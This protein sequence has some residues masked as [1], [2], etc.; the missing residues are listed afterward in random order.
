MPKISDARRQE[1]RRQ[2]LAAAM[3]CFARK[4]FEQTTVL[5]ICAE[6]GLSAG[7]V[8]SY[9]KS[10]RA[11]IE[12]LSSEARVLAV[13]QLAAGGEGRA[14]LEQLRGLLKGLERPGGAKT[15]QLDVRSWADAIGDRQ[16]RTVFLKARADWAE[17]LAALI[18]DSARAKGL[19]SESLAELVVAVITGCELRRAIEPS[20]DLGPLLDTLIALLA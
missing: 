18:G 7:A 17:A 12:A 1:R 20:A 16:M 3:S 19:S 15:F 4:G 2:I 14:P 9:F 11:I 5:D 6:S 8:Y 10:K 13:D